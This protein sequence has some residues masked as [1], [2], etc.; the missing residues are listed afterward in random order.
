MVEAEV[1]GWGCWHVKGNYDN[2]EEQKLWV[3]KDDYEMDPTKT[4]NNLI[5]GILFGL[6]W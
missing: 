3:P 4:V 6:G 2:I 1:M 5:Q